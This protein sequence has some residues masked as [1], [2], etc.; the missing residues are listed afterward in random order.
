[1]G[2]GDWISK[3]LLELG[4]DFIFSLLR[5]LHS[6]G[7]MIMH[8]KGSVASAPYCKHSVVNNISQATLW[9]V[10]NGLSEGSVVIAAPKEPALA[11]SKRYQVSLLAQ[12]AVNMMLP[13]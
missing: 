7:I 1:M 8:V 13:L 4:D 9:I 5:V 11:I 10:G 12:S 3:L 2:K 6:Q